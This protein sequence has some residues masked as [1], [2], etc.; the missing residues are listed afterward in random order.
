[1]AQTEKAAVNTMLIQIGQSPVNEI[2]LSHPDVRAAL[3]I[4]EDVNREIQS[5]VWW[6][7]TET[8][9]LIPQTDGTLLIPGNATGVL[10]GN[11]SWVKRG[12]KLYDLANHTFDFSEEDT[13]TLDVISEWDLEEL[14]P[15]M[16]TYLI[17]TCRK[18]MQVGF[19]F[20][21]NKVEDLTVEV[22]RSFHDVQVQHLL[23]TGPNAINQ[24]TAQ[25]VLQN[26][27]TR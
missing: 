8:W 13:V 20:D 11:A 2:D 24:A 1:M 19:D 14:P 26:K 15:T 18:K 10:T 4:L 3:Q 9:D 23:F 16:Y 6:Y 5:K 22:Q 27:S 12:R 25:Q 7:N 17:N 21:T